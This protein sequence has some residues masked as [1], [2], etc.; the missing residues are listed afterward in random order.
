MRVLI[1]GGAGF[2]GYHLASYCARQ[3]AHVRIVDLVA[4]DPSEYPPGA[5]ILLGDVRDPAA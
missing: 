4:P 2:L 1:T 5:D 3:G